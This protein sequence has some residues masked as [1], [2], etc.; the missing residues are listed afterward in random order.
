MSRRR[1]NRRLKRLQRTLLTP[2]YGAITSVL[3]TSFKSR[4]FNGQQ[5]AAW[6]PALSKFSWTI[7]V[8]GP[9]ISSILALFAVA[10][11]LIL[12]LDSYFDLNEHLDEL[13]LFVKHLFGWI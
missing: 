4:P 3:F 2:R 1:L 8:L 9:I 10:A 5:I 12:I 13:A 7:R 6:D 11:A